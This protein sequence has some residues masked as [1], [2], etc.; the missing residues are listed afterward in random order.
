MLSI[1]GR[2]AGPG[3]QPMPPA[4]RSLG[5]DGH[6]GERGQRVEQGVLK[7]LVGDGRVRAPAPPVVPVATAGQRLGIAPPLY[8]RRV[9]FFAKNR[10]FDISKAQRE[11]GYSPRQEVEAEVADVI[12][13]Y[14]QAGML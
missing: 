3:R 9:D 11:I 1:T 10:I 14:R 13:W 5:R 12:A 7:R 2:K 8:R 4:A 6:A